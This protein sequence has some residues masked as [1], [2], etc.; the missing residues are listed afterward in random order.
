[1]LEVFYPLSSIFFFCVN[2]RQSAV[3]NYFLSIFFSYV[4]EFFI[5]LRAFVVSANR[6]RLIAEDFDSDSDEEVNY[7]TPGL[8]PFTLG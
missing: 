1:M 5:H 7:I 2:G 4:F 3:H 8:C 6:A